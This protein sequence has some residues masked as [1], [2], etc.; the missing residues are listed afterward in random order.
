MLLTAIPA[1]S[2]GLE[3]SD[4]MYRML[5]KFWMGAPLLSSTNG[6]ATYP[7]CSEDTDFF[8]DHFLCCKRYDFHAQ[9]DAV[10]T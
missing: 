10:V 2:L 4:A 1:A 3:L 7:F 5:A 8:A 9:Y 6:V